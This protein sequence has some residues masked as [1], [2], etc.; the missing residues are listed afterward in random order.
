MI[1]LNSF[2]NHSLPTDLAENKRNPNSEILL[3]D[4]AAIRGKASGGQAPN[5][6][7]SI[8]SHAGNLPGNNGIIAGRDHVLISK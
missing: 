8:I 7:G 6:D 5:G 1:W 4:V 2:V 3:S